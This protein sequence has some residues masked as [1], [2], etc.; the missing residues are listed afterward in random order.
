MLPMKV[1]AEDED[2]SRQSGMAQ[3][4]DALLARA[5]FVGDLFLDPCFLFTPVSDRHQQPPQEIAVSVAIADAAGRQ[6]DGQAKGQAERPVKGQAEGQGAEVA[7]PV[8]P[9][10]RRQTGEAMLEAVGVAGRLAP[11][12][13]NGQANQSRMQVQIPLLSSFCSAPSCY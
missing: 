11:L 13:S 4:P 8:K 6:A 7:G 9:K 2:Q 5:S 10:A 12:S 3:Q 1:L